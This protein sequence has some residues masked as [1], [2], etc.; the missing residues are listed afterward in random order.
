MN[1]E[2]SLKQI[3][4]LRGLKPYQRIRAVF[5]LYNF[6]RERI[7]AEI[8]RN[9]PNINKKELLDKLNRRFVS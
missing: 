5:E 8:R 1:K 4:V 9:N 2:D 3:E 6:A 7:A